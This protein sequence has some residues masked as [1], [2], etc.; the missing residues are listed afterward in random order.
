MKLFQ[1]F[2][3]NKILKILFRVDLTLLI[4]VFL[5]QLLGVAIERNNTT[6][7]SIAVLYPIALIS[8]ISLI[9]LLPIT[10]IFALY[11]FLSTP[12]KK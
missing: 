5:F 2:L 1:I 3:Q 9:L 11:V 4:L 6:N 7:D 12:R 10:L 8:V